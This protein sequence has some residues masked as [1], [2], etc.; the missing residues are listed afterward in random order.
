VIQPP[1]VGPMEG[2]GR[3]RGRRGEGLAALLGFKA[4]RHNRLGHGLQAAA[5]CPLEDAEDEQHGQRERR[6][7]EEAGDG[8]D[9]DAENEEIA[10]SRTLEPIH[11]WKNNALATR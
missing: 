11:P 3:R 10:S 5:A 6:A 8:K 9:D 7:A 4:V 1:R 2:R